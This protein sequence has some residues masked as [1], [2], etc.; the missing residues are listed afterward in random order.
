MPRDMKLQLMIFLVL[1]PMQLRSEETNNLYIMSQSVSAEL[2]TAKWLRDSC[3]SAVALF[4]DKDAKLSEKQGQ[5]FVT[6]V[7]Y[8]NGMMDGLNKALWLYKTDD[9][10]SLL[11]TPKGWGDF[12]VVAPSILSFMTAHEDKISDQTPASE[13][14]AAW[15]FYNHPNATESDKSKGLFFLVNQAAKEKGFIPETKKEP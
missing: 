1:L 9:A 4:A 2:G 6:T 8:I 15:Y 7:L 11:F 12:A 10:P 14:V 5:G 13:V 3:S